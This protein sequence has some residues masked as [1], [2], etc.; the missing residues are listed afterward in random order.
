LAAPNGRSK[1]PNEL[2][3]KL[4]GLVPQSHGG[5]LLTGG[6]RGHAGGP[7]RPPS[8]LRERLRGSF[9]QRVAVLETIADDPGAD[10]QDRIRAVDVLAKYGLG[11]LREVSADEVRERLRAT[12][13]I[14]RRELP[15]GVASHVIN[16][17]Q[18]VWTA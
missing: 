8:A 9:A 7:G 18:G 16:L 3:A 12:I 4:A 11:T 10:S 17:L 14:L 1:K 6:V 2:A 13:H 15:S 5:A